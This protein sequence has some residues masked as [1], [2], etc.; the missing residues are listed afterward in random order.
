MQLNNILFK[1]IK[2]SLV[3]NEYSFTLSDILVHI[4][5]AWLLLFF[6]QYMYLKKKISQIISMHSPTVFYIFMILSRISMDK[7]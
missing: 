1:N 3:P 4:H 2:S 6:P 7:T 5:K